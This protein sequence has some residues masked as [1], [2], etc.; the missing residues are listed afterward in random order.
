MIYF[1]LENGPSGCEECTGKGRPARRPLCI[2]GE[3]MSAWAQLAV[4]RESGCVWVTRGRQNPWA[5]N[6]DQMWRLLGSEGSGRCSA[7]WLE[8]PGGWC[9][10]LRRHKIQEEEQNES[11]K[12]RCPHG[13]KAHCRGLEL[14]KEVWA[15]DKHLLV[16]SIC[17]VI[18]AIRNARPSRKSLVKTEKSQVTQL[19]RI[20]SFE[21]KA[22]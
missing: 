15:A 7:T 1:A 16:I 18:E 8:L 17:E 21:Q 10:Y 4:G 20:D 2:Y 3:M 14:R 19:C 12:R 9:W 6:K 22:S 11:G 13:F 5:L